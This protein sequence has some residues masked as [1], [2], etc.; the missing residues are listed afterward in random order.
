MILIQ[1]LQ[2]LHPVHDRHTYIGKQHIDLMVQAA[3]QY[4]HSIDTGFDHMMLRRQR[5]DILF[6]PF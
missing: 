3:I 1:L 6:H 5:F 2:Q 4:L